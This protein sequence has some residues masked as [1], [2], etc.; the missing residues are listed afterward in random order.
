MYQRILVAIDG[1]AAATRALDEALHLAVEYHANL[2]L[3]HV[4]EM[5]YVGDGMNIDFNAMAAERAAPARAL[6]AEASAHVR[7]VGIEPEVMLRSSDGGRI[8]EVIVAEAMQ[9][10]A[11]LIVLGTHGHGLMQ[12]LLGSTTEDVLRVMPVPLLLVR[13]P[14]Y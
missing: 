6:L 9:W 12:R 3:M 11:D 2:G 4:I 1:G 5:P 13:G 10:S 7:R 14:E 8:G